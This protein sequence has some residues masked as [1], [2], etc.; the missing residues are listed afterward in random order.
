MLNYLKDKLKIQKINDIPKYGRNIDFVFQRLEKK[1]LN[2][3]KKFD[4][5]DNKINKF[6][7][8]HAID[9]DESVTHLYINKNNNDIIAC[10]SLSCSGIILDIDNYSYIYPAVEIKMFAVDKKYQ[11]KP[12]SNGSDKTLSDVIFNNV[13]FDVIDSFTENYCGATHVILYS[14]IKAVHFYQKHNFHS[15]KEYL[16]D[17]KSYSLKRNDSYTVSECIPLFFKYN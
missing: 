14:K 11:G 12:F 17:D 4:C 10:V 7:Q 8:K 3:L 16:V 5:T 15:F 1:Y 13:L 6:F 9:D 2:K